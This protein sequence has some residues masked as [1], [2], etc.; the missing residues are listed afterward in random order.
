MLLVRATSNDNTTN[1]V[2]KPGRAIPASLESTSSMYITNH[3]SNA[4]VN[5]VSFA[6]EENMIGNTGKKQN[7]AVTTASGLHDNPRSLRYASIELTAAQAR[8]ACN[9]DNMNMPIS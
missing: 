4:I 8:N 3:A 9:A 7:T 6:I 5:V 1:P 2:R